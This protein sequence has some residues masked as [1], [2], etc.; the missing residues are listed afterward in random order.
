MSNLTRLNGLLKMRKQSGL[1]L[2]LLTMAASN[3]AAQDAW[4]KAES[5]WYVGAGVGFTHMS[6]DVPLAVNNEDFDEKGT[7]FDLFVGYDFEPTWLLGGHWAAEVGYIDFGSSSQYF[8]FDVIAGPPGP[9]IVLIPD[10]PSNLVFEGY[11]YYLTS[12]YKIPTGNRGSVDL[13]VG[14][15]L[16][17][18]E[19]EDTL[20][21]GAKADH[22]DSGALLGIAYTFKAT[23]TIAVR[24]V[25]NYYQLDFDG[26]IDKPYRLG[27]DLIWNIK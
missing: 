24:A 9:P 4:Y 3:V 14:W 27:V 13:S 26:V 8:T 19:A 6:Q 11:G 18:S 16:G 2:A 21:A 12:Q 25:A 20:N 7:G 23:E 17:N 10:L 5:P 15:I 1:L 22:H